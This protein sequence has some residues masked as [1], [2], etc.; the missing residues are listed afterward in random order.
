MQRHTY[1]VLLIHTSL[2]EAEIVTFV[3]NQVMKLGG[4]ASPGQGQLWR[5]NLEA[6]KKHGKVY[7]IPKL[8]LGACCQVLA[9]QK[10][11]EGQAL[12]SLSTLRRF[13]SF[14]HHGR[15]LPQN[16]FRRPL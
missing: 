5:G 3:Q 11:I 10:F 13:L 4:N 9:I 6:G 7:R 15:R 12:I 14:Y 2:T 1:L 16:S 8:A